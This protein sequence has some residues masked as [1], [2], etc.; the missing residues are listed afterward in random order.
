VGEQVAGTKIHNSLYEH[1]N[2]KAWSVVSGPNEGILNAVVDFSPT[3][4]YAFADFSTLHWNGTA[5]SVVSGAPGALGVSA[6]GS[7][8]IWGIFRNDQI[9]H[10]NGTSWT[11]TTLST[12]SGTPAFLDVAAVSPT[13]VW[14]DGTTE[15][16]ALVE[17]FN[18]TSWHVV[19][20]P[21]SFPSGLQDITAQSATD[22]WVFS[23]TGTPQAPILLAQ[24]NGSSWTTDPSPVP[25][26]SE[27]V[28]GSAASSPSHVW[29]FGSDYTSGQ[30]L[31]LNDST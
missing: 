19:P 5:W 15:T 2:G 27:V 29:L 9:I 16:S 21:S 1:W 20:T 17:H 18:G 24:W 7:S 23:Y 4:A 22:V 31:I 14:V 12:P 10:Y 3:N 25:A 6:D 26:G 13:D 28:L 11:V 8:D 30:A